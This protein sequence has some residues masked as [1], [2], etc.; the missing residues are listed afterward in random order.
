MIDFYD[1][2]N[3]FEK[4]KFKMAYK[5]LEQQIMSFDDNMV[6]ILSKWFEI[7]E[8][9]IYLNSVFKKKNLVD[10]QIESDDWYIPDEER[11]KDEEKTRRY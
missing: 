9:Q 8:N 4:K 3:V 7:Y 11:E 1:E 10:K 2:L 5:N 6:D